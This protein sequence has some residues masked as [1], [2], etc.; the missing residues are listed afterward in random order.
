MRVE[1]SLLLIALL[2]ACGGSSLFSVDGGVGRRDASAGTSLDAAIHASDAGARW[3]DAGTTP[4]GD[5]GSA[6]FSCWL[7]DGAQAIKISAD[8]QQNQL[9]DLAA[10]DGKLGV[11]YLQDGHD[12][13]LY[14]AD[15]SWPDGGADAVTFAELYDGT[16]AAIG[17]A[18][19]AALDFADDGL[20][21]VA[22]NSA[23]GAAAPLTRL[24]WLDAAGAAKGDGTT[25]GFTAMATA[26]E[27]SG[28][29]VLALAL[30][31]GAPDGGTEQ[32]VFANRYDLSGQ[33]SGSFEVGRD[34]RTT[35][36]WD[37][38]WTWA[39]DTGLAC[40]V[41]LGTDSELLT[42]FEVGATAATAHPTGEKLVAPAVAADDSFGCRIALDGTQVVVALSEGEA[43]ARLLW[44]SPTGDTLAGPVP[45]ATSRGASTYDVAAGGGLTALAFLD[46]SSGVSHVVVRVWPA[47]GRA[48]FELDAESGLGLNGIDLTGRR[49]RLAAV[50][51]GFLVAFDA[52]IKTGQ[53]D[54]YVRRVQCQ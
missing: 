7:D 20:F 41:S 34:T 17:T 28:A 45:F 25:N 44:L 30:A 9:A 53:G 13:R 12:P 1:G 39:D 52:G 11:A 2:T 14:V 16:T 38:A 6:G 46:D 22:G 47:P 54:L 10:R 8:L 21:F 48:P 19:P 51:G 31:Q 3:Q 32:L 42:L 4:V 29:L 26:R 40:G 36:E 5:A 49:V 18:T 33:L 43:K 24:A 37:L 15:Y 27:P 23:A 50:A 35:N